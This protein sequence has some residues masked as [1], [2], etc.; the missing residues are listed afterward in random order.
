MTPGSKRLPVR[1]MPVAVDDLDAAFAYINERNLV[2]ARALE[3]RLSETLDR[4]SAFPEMGA[5]LATDAFD[6]ARPGTRLV[7]VEPYLVFYRVLPE[8]V[9]ILRVLHASQDSLG[10]LFE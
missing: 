7:V 2:E 8:A 5:A 4:L 9:V 3:A 10:A 6:F 1:F